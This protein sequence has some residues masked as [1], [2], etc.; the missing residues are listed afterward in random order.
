LKLVTKPYFTGSMPIKKTIGI[1]EAAMAA[2][3][4]SWRKVF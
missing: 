3:V 4:R 1:V 2:F